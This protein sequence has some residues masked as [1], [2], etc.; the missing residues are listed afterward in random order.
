[1]NRLGRDKGKC[2]CQNFDLYQS[3]VRLI[4][5]IIKALNITL[6]SNKLGV[7]GYFTR[8]LLWLGNCNLIT[9]LRKNRFFQFFPS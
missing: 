4:R 9:D 5:S 7:S 8:Y 2:K 1:M 6:T 3:I